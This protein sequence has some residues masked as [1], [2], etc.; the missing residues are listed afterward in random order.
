[1]KFLCI[2]LSLV[3]LGLTVVTCKNNRSEELTI[4]GL[5]YYRNDLLT[6]VP[7]GEKDALVS[8][9][10]N[11][12]N[13]AAL[14][15]DTMQYYYIGEAAYVELKG[16]LQKPRRK[17]IQDKPLSYNFTVDRIIYL[18]KRN[19][20]PHDCLYCD[21]SGGGYDAEWTFE[22]S[23]IEAQITLRND[24]AKQSYF[25]DYVEPIEVNDTLILYNAQNIPAGNKIEIKIGRLIEVGELSST[26]EFPVTIV[27]NDKQFTGY[28]RQCY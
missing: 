6:L 15:K 18:T 19:N 3:L 28:A 17:L 12:G 8:I 9:I 5:L 27:L 20:A 25:F 11:T 24:E 16:S 26:K 21:F 13:L 1:M 22:I 2:K 14:Y 7:C 4:S 23:E 10:D